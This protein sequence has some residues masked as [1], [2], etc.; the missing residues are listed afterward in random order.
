[1]YQVVGTDVNG[2]SKSDSVL[3]TVNQLPNVNAGVNDSICLGNSFTLNATGALSYVWNNGVTNNVPFT[4]NASSNYIVTGTDINGCQKSDTMN[5]TVLALPVVSIST[6]DSTVI[7]QG[8]TVNI[9]SSVNAIVSYV[10][11]N[12]NTN[13]NQN[14]SSLNV[15]TSGSYSLLVED[16]FG[17]ENTSDTISVTVHQYPLATITPG[18]SLILCNGENVELNANQGPLLTYSWQLIGNP[19]PG[20]NTDSLVVSSAGTYQLVTT[21][22]GLCSTTSTP[23][24]V[25]VN[26]LPIVSIAFVGPQEVCQG[27]TVFF[28][29]TANSIVSYQWYG[30][31]GNAIQNQSLSTFNTTVPGTY[32]VEAENEFGCTQN[33]NSLAATNYLLPQQ[34]ID[35]C[36]VTVDTAT[37]ANKVLWAKPSGAYRV[38][39]YNIYRETSIAGQYGIVGS[40]LDTALTE[41]VDILA[42]P[43]VQ[44]YRYKIA[45]VDSCGIESAKS[46]LHRTIHLSSN[47]GINGEINLSWNS[48]EGFAYPT[49]DILRSVNGSPFVSI[50]QISSNSNSYTDLNPPAGVKNY[51]ISVDIPNGGCTPNKSFG[52]TIS[53]RI[54]VGT[55]S[56]SV[57]LENNIEVYPNPSN[58]IFNIVLTDISGDQ[59]R[60]FEIVNAIGQLV[61]EFDMESYENKKAI[62]LSAY[63]NGLYFLKQ[64]DG[65][66]MKQLILNQ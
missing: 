16:G 14:G 18:S 43:S 52:S 37:N 30:S 64:K 46:E 62:D 50:A 25:V 60:K 27:D 15:L 12:T 23:V 55:A 10:W 17:C 45:H 28:T 6:L 65:N 4:P 57:D 63:A 53:N 36:A 26:P 19:I 34:I 49:F 21:Y 42:N 1:M 47:S 33:S 7:C 54:S 66:W 22:D 38:W 5:L 44:S 56:L 41:Y 24:T 61:M 3:V 58:G 29:A 35:I 8:D 13:I 59:N 32:Y 31:N 20:G 2:C 9:T 39:Y 51:M 40:V 11:Y 48:Y